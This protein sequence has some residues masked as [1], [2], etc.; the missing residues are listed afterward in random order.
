[1]RSLL[2]SSPVYHILNP[3]RE[4]ITLGPNTWLSSQFPF[5]PR[6]STGLSPDFFQHVPPAAMTDVLKR[7][8]KTDKTNILINFILHLHF[9]LCK[10]YQFEKNLS[11]YKEIKGKRSSALSHRHHHL[12]EGLIPC[13]ADR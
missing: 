5:G 10:Y 8:T 2:P 3:L 1:M 4:A 6:F 9:M 12:Y 13:D 7:I 11:A